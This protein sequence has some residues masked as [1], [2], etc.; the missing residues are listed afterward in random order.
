MGVNQFTDML[1]KEFEGLMLTSINLTDATSDIDIIY[2]APENTEIPSS[3]DWRVKGAVT[4][5]KN[6]GKCGSCWAFSAVG[7][8]EGQQFLKTRQLKSLSTQNLLDCS[9]RYP[10]SN[11]GCN[12]GI[13]LEAL[14]YVK[15]NGGID[16]ESSYPYDSRQLSC[17]FD[18]HNVGA[19]VSAV[20]RLTEGDESNLA[21][22]TATKGPISVLI[23]VGQTFMQYHGG[24][25]K[26]NSCNKY[27]NHAVLVV[28]Y[29]HD[30]REGD[31]WL[32][33]NSWGSK[34]GES[35]YIRMARNRNNQCRIAS[36]AIFPLV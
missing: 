32:V 31:Y 14:I 7:T 23:H 5:V 10:Y 19:T 27:F 11:Q 17:R 6:Q 15:D 1:P 29:G 13:P 21:V 9:S 2:S 8:L 20:V 34:W 28:G 26:D 36:Y 22:A 4:S 25:Y 3:I 30:S 18:R 24:V 12:G 16:I 33:K 35:G